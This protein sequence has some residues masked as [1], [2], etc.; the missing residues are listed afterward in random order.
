MSGRHV[1]CLLGLGE[2]GNTLATDFSASG[3]ADLAAWDWQFPDPD[4][5]PSRH[6]AACPRLRQAAS[7]EA[8]A[9]GCSIVISAVT[10]AQDLAAAESILPGVESG[11]WFLDLNSVSP[12]TKQA[13]ADAVERSGGRYVEAA[14]MSPIAPQR[15]AS[16]ILV[17]GPHAGDFLPVGRGLG[18]GNLRFCDS[19]IG[20]A[21]ATKMC[22]S[23]VIKG[24]EAVL[25]EALVAA[26]N[27]GVDGAVIES[28]QNLLPHPDW[29]GHARYMISR[30][31]EHGTRRA[32]EMREAARTA[33]EAGL[34]PLMSEACAR[35]QDW[36][37]QYA[38]ALGQPG[39]E[40]MLE[41]I[42][43]Q[44]DSGAFAARKE[45]GIP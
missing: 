24:M 28:L 32:E 27:Y 12:A 19:R 33:A 30:A 35:R 8:A 37:P 45:T 31:L 14:I 38:S 1:I 34:E 26:R 9:T 43:E 7:A 22:R 41:A 17:G 42:L 23:I 29:E 2:V 25:T 13:V 20:K 40:S 3:V 15:L 16:P 10:A 36:A 44:M 21:S 11:A 18:F 39:L 6:A 4:S 5:T